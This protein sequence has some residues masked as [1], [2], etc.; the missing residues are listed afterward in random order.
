MV[1]RQS[2]IPCRARFPGAYQFPRSSGRRFPY[3]T[4]EGAVAAAPGAVLDAIND[5]REAAGVVRAAREA[6]ARAL[7]MLFETQA[8]AVA[9]ITDPEQSATVMTDVIM[10]LLANS[11]F[12][13]LERLGALVSAY[14]HIIDAELSRRIENLRNACK[15]LKEQLKCSL[16]NRRWS[17]GCMHQLLEPTAAAPGS[18]K[19]ARRAESARGFQRCTQALSLVCKRG[20]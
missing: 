16:S 14:G 12:A 9:G 8:K 13:M 7:D 3:F 17:I 15:A 4:T 6:T 2:C 18:A 10:P 1:Y 11:D 19:R 5:A 20:S